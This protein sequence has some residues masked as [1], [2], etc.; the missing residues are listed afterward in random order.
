M[1]EDIVGTLVFV[2][3]IDTGQRPEL[4]RDLHVPAHPS[5]VLDLS[6]VGLEKLVERKEEVVVGQPGVIVR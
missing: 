3:R 2:F 5:P 4:A 6:L 1:R